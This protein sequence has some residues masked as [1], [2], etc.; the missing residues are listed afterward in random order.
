MKV[1]SVML[2]LLGG[3]A[4]AQT[5]APPATVQPSAAAAPSQPQSPPLTRDQ[6]EGIRAEIRKG[7]SD[8]IAKNVSL[9]ADEAAKFWPIYKQYEAA[10]K[11]LNDKRFDLI[12]KYIDAGDKADAAMATNVVKASLQRDID[13]AKLRVEYA[14][15][16]AKVLPKAKA[17]RVLQV[18]RALSLMID[19]KLASM[20]PL[21]PWYPWPPLEE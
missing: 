5:T 3:A 16:F 15:K 21:L 20:V 1:L 4:L 18:D 11:A 13:V 6:I 9:T 19:A 10:G 17:A 12:T 8:L 14:P 2:L 7:K